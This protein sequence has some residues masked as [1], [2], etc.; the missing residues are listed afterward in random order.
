MERLMQRDHLETDAILRRMNA[1][2]SDAFFRSHAD[3]VIENDGETDALLPQV[4]HILT[5]TG[6]L[7][8]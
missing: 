2:R 8:P 5:E 7:P 4:R 6:V 3:Y 1:Q